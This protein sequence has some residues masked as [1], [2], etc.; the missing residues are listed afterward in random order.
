M[1]ETWLISAV[2]RAR[3]IRALSVSRLSRETCEIIK[4]WI[5]ARLVESDGEL[6]GLT[7]LMAAKIKCCGKAKRYRVRSRREVLARQITTHSTRLAIAGLSC[8]TCP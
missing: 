8:E 3:S 1:R 7:Q 2:R 5:A 4:L 6:N